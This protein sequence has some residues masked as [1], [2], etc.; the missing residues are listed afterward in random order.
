MCT[1]WSKEKI[2]KS[3]LLYIII[4]AGSLAINLIKFMMKVIEK[5]L[6][7]LQGLNI[8]MRAYFQEKIGLSTW[9]VSITRNVDK[10]NLING[11]MRNF[12]EKDIK[13]FGNCWHLLSL[14]AKVNHPSK[15]D[16]TFIKTLCSEH[17]ML[18]SYKMLWENNSFSYKKLQ[19]I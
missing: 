4:M 2:R 12:G 7:F 10:L 16:F 6:S 3:L 1:A 5:E 11:K 19:N 15:Q 14:K 8:L 13:I 9:N 17:F 18:I